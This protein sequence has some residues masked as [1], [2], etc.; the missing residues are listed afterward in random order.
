[1]GF[2]EMEIKHLL[3]RSSNAAFMTYLRNISQSHL[4]DTH[5][6]IEDASAIPNFL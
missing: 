4:S 5:T 1:M 3:R 2:H 6:A